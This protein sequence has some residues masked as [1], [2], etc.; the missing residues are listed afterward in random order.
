MKQFNLLWLQSGGCGGV[1]KF[2]ASQ[3]AEQPRVAASPVIFQDQQATTLAHDKS[4]PGRFKRAA[5]FMGRSLYAGMA[6]Q[7][8]DGRKFKIM[9]RIQQL[10]AAADNGNVQN[11]I[12][13]H[14]NGAVK[15]RLDGPPE[16]TNLRPQASAVRRLP[17]RCRTCPG[18]R[19]E[20]FSGPMWGPR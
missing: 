5:V 6:C 19:I 14:L 16:N 12:L 20:A 2:Q 9:G 4:V 1:L 13:D 18:L 11:I 7:C 3:I 17:V 15:C 10:F 8:T